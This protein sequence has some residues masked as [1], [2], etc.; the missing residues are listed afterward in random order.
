MSTTIR[1]P[2]S[3]YAR[4]RAHLLTEGR[5]EFYGSFLAGVNA[6]SHRVDL[7]ARE[8]V[9]VPEDQV[10]LSEDGFELP[11]S[12][13]LSIR[14][15]AHAENAALI[16]AHSHPFGPAG[17]SRTDEKW[18]AA[19]AAH[20]LGDLPGRPYAATVW[21]PGSIDGRLWRTSGN[22]W[23]QID[24][25]CVLSARIER[26]RTTGADRPQ[27]MEGTEVAS[28]RYSRQVKALGDAGQ[29]ELTSAQIGII[30]LGGLGSISAIQLAYAGVRRF[31]LVDWD[32]VEDTNLN[33]LVG[34]GP[35][36]I[37]RLKTEVVEREILRISGVEKCEIQSFRELRGLRAIEALTEVDCLVGAVDNDAARLILNELAVAY[38]VPYFDLGV[39]IEARDGIVVEAGGRVT[40]V[41]PDGPCLLCATAYSPRIA[42]EELRNHEDRKRAQAL[43]CISGDGDPSPSVVTLN[44]VVSGLGMTKLP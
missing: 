26:V 21:S 44:T 4:A 9:A 24:E 43:G 27:P 33:R 42:A 36:D 17:F 16:E 20:I 41:H 38:M 25:L 39:G 30:G 22:E 2:S 5:G 7:L 35:A 37:G 11:L 14:N 40:F 32:A 8:F 13:W 28:P 6:I 12:A 29:D 31:V 23:I 18:S 1:I 19:F 34:A 10:H 3:V 15:R